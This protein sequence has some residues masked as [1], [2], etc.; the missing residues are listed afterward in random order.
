MAAGLSLA[1][2]GVATQFGRFA[3][4]AALLLAPMVYV[5]SRLRGHAPQA[6]T[7]SDLVGAVLGERFGV[8]AGL[9]QLVAYMLLA[10]KFARLFAMSMRGTFLAVQANVP[11]G[12]FVFGAILAAVAAGVLIYQLSTRGLAWVAAILAALGMLVHFYLALALV[13]MIAKGDE[14]RN[15]YIPEP[16]PPY[17]AYWLIAVLLF[18]GFEV[19]TTVNRDVRSVGRSMGLALAL[20]AGC[21]LTVEAAVSHRLWSSIRMPYDWQ[22]SS[23]AF[24]YLDQAGINWLLVAN[25]A[26][27]YAGLL[28]LTLAA[29]RVARRLAQQLEL[30]LQYG[31]LL[32]GVVAIVGVL[33]IVEWVW[34]GVASNVGDVGPLLLLAVYACA[35][36]AYARIPDAGPTLVAAA[37]RLFIWVVVASVVVVPLRGPDPPATWVSRLVITAVVLLAALAIAAKTDRLPLTS[38]PRE[39]LRE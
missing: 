16:A 5:F 13:G 2:I 10:A 21:A 4:F 36:H 34:R 29:V 38:Q 33:V 22:F 26:F 30:P 23:L 28:T 19:V 1:V 31:A 18:V 37:V 12:W 7:T 15:P 9:I 6:R 25:L 14:P 8:F 11:S 24:A 17:M 32:A 3:V 27:S 39:E 20:S 35:A